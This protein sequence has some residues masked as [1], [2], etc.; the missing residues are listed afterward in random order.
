[1]V[2]VRVRDGDEQGQ[3]MVTR[4]GDSGNRELRAGNSGEGRGQWRQH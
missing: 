4:A 3:G 2:V 1:M